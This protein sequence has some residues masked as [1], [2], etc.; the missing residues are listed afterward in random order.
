VIRRLLSLFS[1]PCV[2]CRTP[3]GFTT[4]LCEACVAH[5]PLTQMW[6]Y[7]DAHDERLRNPKRYR[8]VLKAACERLAA[9]PGPQPLTTTTK[10]HQ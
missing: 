4:A 10:E 3:T 5:L 1:R 7:H 6:D 9:N 2:A 8:D